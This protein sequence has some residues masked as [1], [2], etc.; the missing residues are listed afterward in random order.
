MRGTIILEEYKEHDATM[1]FFA[2]YKL[3]FR[4]NRP[5]TVFSGAYLSI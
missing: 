4:D 5:R 2:L 1:T 3:T